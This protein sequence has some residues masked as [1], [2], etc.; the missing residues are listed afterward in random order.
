MYHGHLELTNS[1]GHHLLPQ[2]P[3]IS[4]ITDHIISRCKSSRRYTADH[5]K[6]VVIYNGRNLHGLYTWEKTLHHY[7]DKP[8]NEDKGY[9]KLIKDPFVQVVGVDGKTTLILNPRGDQSK[10]NQEL[11]KRKWGLPTR[12]KKNL[13]ENL[14]E[15]LDSSQSAAKG[16]VEEATLS[17][18]KPG[19]ISLS[20][21][22][23]A[24]AAA[25]PE[26]ALNLPWV[27]KV[28]AGLNQYEIRTKDGS[29][30]FQSYKH[31][32]VYQAPDGKTYLD[33][34]HWD[35]SKTT[36]KY[37]ALFLNET[38]KETEAKIKSGEYTLVNLNIGR[39]P[40]R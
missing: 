32:I 4:A 14:E 25:T 11:N 12:Y 27:A 23:P 16:Q 19:N 40:A 33:R 38:R 37:R 8:G 7:W 17:S 3:S 26:E 1:T 34:I 9:L 36:S 6:T 29:R 24:A 21:Q 10:M 15:F 13:E 30:T 5:I 22:V 28:N 18:N 39:P 35:F 31:R 2:L 20:V